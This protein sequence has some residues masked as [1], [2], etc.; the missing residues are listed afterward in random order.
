MRGR[1]AILVDDGIATGAT[2]LVAIRSARALGA[3]RVVLATPVASAQAT[4]AL[5][6]Y[7]DEVIVLVTP[8]PFQAV[9]LHYREFG[10]LDD[11]AVIRRL[12]EAS[13]GT[14]TT[15]PVTARIDREAVQI[16]AGDVTLPAL[17]SVPPSAVGMVI[18]A[19]G[20]GS[21]RLSPRNGAVAR[22]L[23]ESGLATLLAD[24]LT[25]EEAGD[26]RKV[27][28][29][30]LLAGRLLACAAYVGQ[31]HHTSHLP[32]GLFGA[33]TGAG[34]ALVAAADGTAHIRAVVSR[35][36]RPDLAARALEA[37]QAPTLLLVGSADTAVIALNRHAFDRL[38]G[39]KRLVLIP[40]ATHLFEEPGTLDAVARHARDWFLR[41]VPA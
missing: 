37:V 35:G 5:A 36:G 6:P 12:R 24:L 38:H 29:I 3:S 8:E 14:L 19:H 2:A 16:P 4:S 41:Y 21:G 9:G 11:D 17:L 31:N 40:G 26:R 27:F 18:F 23:D 20:S 32:L 7:A 1:V 34:A 39:E 33:S 28:D 10:Q 15:T 13:A 22:V 25:E 30:G